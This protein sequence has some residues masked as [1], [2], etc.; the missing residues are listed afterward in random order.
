MRYHSQCA[1]G[2]C[3]V[4]KIIE[5][6]LLFDFYGDLLTAHQ[7]KIYSEAVFNDLSLAELSEEE[8]ISR[9]GVFD[10]IKRCD[11]LLLEYES[12]LKLIEKFKEIKKEAGNL[13]TKVDALDISLDLK[14]EL[15]ESINNII[16][17]L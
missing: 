6:G 12:K 8:G 7:Q 9:Q 10:L 4:D 5:R 14:N 13:E 2:R 17:N 3:M 11:K 15:K 1:L 16:R